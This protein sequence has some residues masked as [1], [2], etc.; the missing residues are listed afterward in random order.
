MTLILSAR[1]RCDFHFKGTLAAA[2][3]RGHQEAETHTEG[4]WW[5][6]VLAVGWSGGFWI[7]TVVGLTGCPGDGTWVGTHIENHAKYFA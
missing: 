1:Q 5:G 3:L 6:G 2:G 4:P 7:H